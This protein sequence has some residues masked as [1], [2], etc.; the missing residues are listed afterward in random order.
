MLDDAFAET[1]RDERVE[2][3]VEIVPSQR[4]EDPTHEI[5]ERRREEHPQLFAE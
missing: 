5:D 4:E 3:G 1:E 2:V